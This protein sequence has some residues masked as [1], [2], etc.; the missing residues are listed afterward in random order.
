MILS[1]R[2]FDNN[3]FCFDQEKLEKVC[4]IFETFKNRIKCVTLFVRH[5][6][7]REGALA[8]KI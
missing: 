2:I 4:D 1:K 5:K 8:L 7:Q 6:C 3:T